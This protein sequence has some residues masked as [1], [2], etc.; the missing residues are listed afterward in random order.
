[1][2]RTLF[3]ETLQHH[4]IFVWAV[5]PI[6]GTVYFSGYASQL[7]GLTAEQ[8]RSKPVQQTGLREAGF[9]RLVDLMEDALSGELAVDQE[10]VRF[11][12]P[13][14]KRHDLQIRLYP[15]KDEE[16]NADCIVYVLTGM[17]VTERK[18][19]EERLHLAHEGSGA[20]IWES[21]M[22]TQEYT[23]SKRWKDLMGYEERRE[24]YNG[25]EIL[26]LIHP[27][28][29]EQAKMKRLGHLRGEET[30][31]NA[32]YRM[33]TQSG[34]YRWMQVRGKVL[35]DSYGRGVRFAG[36]L[37]DITERKNYELQLKASLEE[38]E[39]TNRELAHI[40]EEL[41][42]QVDLLVE[43]QTR[44]RQNEDKLQKL[45]YFDPVSGLPNRVLLLEKL[46][47]SL[48]DMNRQ[49]ALLFIDTDN[50]KNINDS[51]GHKWG[52]VLIRE[53]GERLN[54]LKPDG[55]M[56][57]RFGSDEFVMLL[58]EDIS[59]KA[60]KLL[61]G[62]LIKGFECPFTAG[63]GELHL[64]ISIG[65]ALY[66]EQASSP[67]ELIKNADL[68]LYRAQKLGKSSFVLYD[69]SMQLELQSRMRM[70]AKLLS[71]L[72]HGEF[73]LVYQPQVDTESGRISGFEAL[74]RWENPELG[75]VAPDKFIRVA[76]DSR[77]II[78][79][80]EWVLL[81]AC[82]FLKNLHNSG[83]EG[84]RI[85]VNIS[86]IQLKQD[87]FVHT[88]ADILKETDLSPE[89]L[90]IEITESLFMESAERNE[91]I[92]KLDQIRQMGIGIA[93]DDFGTGYSSLDYLRELPITTLKMDKKFV[94]PIEQEEASRSLASAILLI[95][96]SLG[97]QIV[98]EG[99]ETN[100]Q[101]EFL[102]K[103]GCDKIQ[104]YLFSK[105]LAGA[106]MAG[107]LTNWEVS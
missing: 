67:E 16:R 85:S 11:S 42:Q 66:P 28:D 81:T 105:P 77:Q 52:D 107:L 103:H 6:K 100:E 55:A 74:L 78:P 46:E 38:L 49:A 43:S 62:R 53:A 61:A 94:D 95:G 48:T 36:S 13:N 51:L 96:H 59:H 82:S 69:A 92:A 4:Q 104:G 44:L 88:M 27:E 102:K 40:Q 34:E 73:M 10:E 19:V 22:T 79:I 90:E 50:F 65:M 15:L 47:S 17:D 12:T 68:A 70:E 91:L 3:K 87:G 93:L 56:L 14:G 71:A 106:E 29:T 18:R 26:S 31:Y 33:L 41:K 75:R 25:A 45:A 72:E 2:T 83:Y 86:V 89:F 54:S 64:S 84:Y 101:F 99:V 8:V 58:I 98:A 60:L 37:I 32:E 21:D 1:M 5:H 76:E 20:I 35:F 30:S 39:H 24:P 80:G 23:F 63:Q 9:G 97:L 57:F 7:T